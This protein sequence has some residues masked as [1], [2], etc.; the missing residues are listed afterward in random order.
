MDEVFEKLR[1]NAF[2]LG[3]G[4]SP[5]SMEMER[6]LLNLHDLTCKAPLY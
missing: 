3:I 5:L 1:C 2:D 6:S 4:C